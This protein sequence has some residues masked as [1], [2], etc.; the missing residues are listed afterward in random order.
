MIRY[1]SPLFGVPPIGLNQF[2]NKPLFLNLGDLAQHVTQLINKLMHSGRQLINLGDP[3]GERICI[4]FSRVREFPPKANP[5]Y[6]FISVSTPTIMHELVP[7]ILQ[8]VNLKD[9][10]V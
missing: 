2:L 3:E 4:W 9:Y 1:D 5:K 8:A 7:I 6:N 10:S